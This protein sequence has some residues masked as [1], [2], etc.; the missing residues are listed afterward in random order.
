M[1]NCVQEKYNFNLSA[2]VNFILRN[3]CYFTDM[4]NIKNLWPSFLQKIVREYAAS[5]FKVRY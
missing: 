2:F 3:V 5:I 4:N 1:T